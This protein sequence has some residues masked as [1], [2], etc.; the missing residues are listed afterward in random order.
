ML[1]FSLTQ[2]FSLLLIDLLQKS[3]NTLKSSASIS[4]YLLDICGCSIDPVTYARGLIIVVAFLDI[5]LQQ[6]YEIPQ[7]IFTIEGTLGN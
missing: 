6:V 7:L 2:V 4:V 1:P 3:E 5:F